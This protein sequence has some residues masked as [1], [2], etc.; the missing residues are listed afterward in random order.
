MFKVFYYYYYLF[1]SKIL[2]QSDPHFVTI[3]ALSFM[4]SLWIN[5]MLDTISVFLYCH[6]IGKYLMIGISIFMLIINFFYYQSEKV[7][8]R[9]LTEKPIFFHNHRITVFIVVG[10]SLIGV[11]WMFWGSMFSKSFLQKC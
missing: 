9:I 6:K 10:I 2:I 8:N 4:E 1:Y 5:G 7:K 3:L 11:S